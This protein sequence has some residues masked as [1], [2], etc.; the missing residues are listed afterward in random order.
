MTYTGIES[1]ECLSCQR[2]PTAIVNGCRNHHRENF[3]S[4]IIDF[5]NGIKCCFGIQCVKASFEHQY[6]YS[7]FYQ[8]AS[9]F[10]IGSSHLVES[11]GTIV[12]TIHIWRQRQCFG[13][14]THGSGNP[15]LAI[16]TV[17]HLPCYSCTFTSH[18]GSYL[19]AII[20]FLRNTIRTE[21]I[22]G[23]DVGTGINISLMNLSD[24]VGVSDIQ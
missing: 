2:S 8:C 22:G 21:R 12:R 5:L 10:F 9:L 16:D 7:A 3:C 15:N 23:D 13:C 14:R 4:F 1:L 17:G 20:F 18:L 11:N 19:F 6:I 24:A